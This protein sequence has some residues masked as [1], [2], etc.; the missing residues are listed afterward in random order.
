MRVPFRLIRDTV[1]LWRASFFE[2]IRL[3]NSPRE[4]WTPGKTHA[5]P[6]PDRRRLGQGGTLFAGGV[7]PPLPSTFFTFAKRTRT[8]LVTQPLSLHLP[9]AP[10]QF[11]S[12]FTEPIKTAEESAFPPRSLQII[13]RSLVDRV[14]RIR[15]D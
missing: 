15:Y 3:I 9:R 1:D 11:V 14:H 4:R 8:P 12:L 6:W 10:S 5:T 2:S 13:E 7:C